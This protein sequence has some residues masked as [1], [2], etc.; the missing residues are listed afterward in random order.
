MKL[1]VAGSGFIVHDWLKIAKEIKGIELVGIT[2]RNES[3]MKELQ[4]EYGI[5]KIYLDYDEALREAD[6]DTVYIAVPNLLHYAYAK[7][8][9]DANKN[10]ICEKPF[11]VYYDQLKELQG[12]A[13]AKDL[14]LVEAITNQ[15]LTNYKK[16]K[17][18]LKDLGPVRI[19]SMNFSQYS[20]RY[21]DFK[22]GNILPVFD[23]K[24]AGGALMDLNVYNIHFV[25][26][27]FGKPKKV[28]YLP[29]IQNGIDTSGILTM[30]YGD[31]K[32]VLIAAK[33]CSAPI[34]S[35]IEGEKG[36]IIVKGPTNELNS[37]EIYRGQDKIKEVA[38]NPYTHR[39]REE[40]EEFNR[41]IEEH[42][43]AEVKKRL[44]HSDAVM[45]VVEKAYVQAGL[46]LG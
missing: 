15:Y 3:V 28:N 1:L 33:D 37:F 8:A 13:L 45:D 23:P 44:D 29:N 24:K 7:K 19:V 10:V 22:A 17:E 20:H 6:I 46:K 30:D 12:Q 14:V 31:F 43:M 4:V 35:T 42:D 16:I 11:T 18:N 27:L 25:V 38:D 5:K 9:L 32:A 40:F 41:M 36:S 34:T 39:M 2:G 21:D 26:G